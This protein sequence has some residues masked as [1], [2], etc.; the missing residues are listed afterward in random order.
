MTVTDAIK[1]R[2]DIVSYIHNL[3]PLKKAGNHWK[4]CCPFHS[5]DHASF[6]VSSDRQS[7]R[8]YGSCADGGDIFAFAMRYHGW[9]FREAL[10]ELGK[11]AGVEVQYANAQTQKVETLRGLV[12][13]AADAYHAALVN[14]PEAA[15]IRAYLAQRGLTP[16]TIKAFNLGWHPGGARPM[17]THLTKM[18]ATEEDIIAAGLAVRKDDGTVFDR[19]S[20]RLIIPIT[21]ERGRAVALAGRR[22]D[23]Q[24]EAKYI[25]TPNSAIFDRSRLLFGY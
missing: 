1:E 6:M 17:F 18:G 2:L 13:A 20:K 7:W 4:A 16:E 11:L 10:E 9:S 22:M 23:G 3:V 12:Q 24:S 21:D 14:R 25:N 5:E 15:E 8:C 19:L